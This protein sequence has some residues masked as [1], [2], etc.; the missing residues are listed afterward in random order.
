MNLNKIFLIGRL[1]QDPETRTTPAGQTVC[2]FSIATNRMW[3]DSDSGE[4]QKKTEFHNIVAWRKLAEICGQYLTKGGLVFIEGRVETRSWE[5]Q[6]GVKKYRTEIVAE[7]M[8]MGPRAASSTTQESSSQPRTGKAP[9]RE[10]DLPIV[11]ADEPN[12]IDIKDIPF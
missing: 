8:Q 9:A 11:N 7:G 12:E 4:R 5:D 3:N 1:T 2:T 6:G 10:E